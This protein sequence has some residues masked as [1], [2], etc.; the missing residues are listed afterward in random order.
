MTSEKDI[1]KKVNI[2]IVENEMIFAED[3]K[4]TLKHANRNYE[5]IEDII[6]SGEKA[7][8]YINNSNNTKP[9]LIIMDLI[10]TESMNGMEVAKTIL[11]N[12]KNIKIIYCSGHFDS[13][14]IEQ[15]ACSGG[16]GY[17]TKPI[18]D[19]P[20]YNLIEYALENND[21]NCF[22]IVR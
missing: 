14:T 22:R 9:D 7:I 15:A 4:Q 19:N 12:N 17:I 13:A 5:V 2:L 8:E 21:P 10:L 20:L 18:E 11:A 1:G 3:L 6:I 16:S